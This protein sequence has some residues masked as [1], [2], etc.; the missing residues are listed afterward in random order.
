MFLGPR[1]GPRFFSASPA[2]SATLA[3]PTPKTRP[4]PA[5]A[6]VAD[7]S[8]PAVRVLRRFR[9]VFNAVKTHFQQVEKRAG[10]GGAQLWALSV[11]RASPGIGVSALAA[12]MDVHQTTASNLVKAL[13]SAEMLTIERK[14]PDRRAVQL[15]VLPAGTRVLQKAP[16]P[17]AGV[18]PQALAALDAATLERLDSDLAK[19]ISA[20]GADQR[21][22]GIPLAQM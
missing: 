11:V 15:R 18:L 8:E 12:A 19:L 3:M 17:F 10:V 7:L 5:A 2:A 1:N 6:A 21:A 20:L 13:V 14:G 4:R 16:G 22:A 9:L